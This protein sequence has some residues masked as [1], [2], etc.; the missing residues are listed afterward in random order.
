[1][2]GSTLTQPGGFYNSRN[3][4]INNNLQNKFIYAARPMERM[5]APAMRKAMFSSQGLTSGKRA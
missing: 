3:L 4:F 1:M 5:T 2:G